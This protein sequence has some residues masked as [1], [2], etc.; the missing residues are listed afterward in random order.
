MITPPFLE[1]GDTIGIIAPAR[2]V[3]E[4]EI[5]PF[6][7]WIGK[8]GYKVKLGESIY[9]HHNQFSGTERERL[10]DL[11]TMIGDDNVK[12]IVAAR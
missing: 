8:M 11:E 10:K 3:I 7:S 9:K 2:S 12:A 4:Q 5:T 6:L 1:R